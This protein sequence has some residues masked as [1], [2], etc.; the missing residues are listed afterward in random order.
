MDEKPD[1]LLLATADWDH[2]LWTN[3]QHV[4]CS[5]AA[6]GHRVLYVESLGLRTIQPTARDWARV[7]KRLRRALQSPR[8]VRPGIWVCAP[9]ILPGIAQ[10]P[11]HWLNRC[12]LNATLAWMQ[13]RLGFG[14]PWLWTYNPLT[15]KY[16]NLNHFGL[17]IYHAVD[18]VQEQPCMPREVIERQEQLLCAAV[19]QVF[20]TSPELRRKLAPMSRR[21]RYDPNVVDQA[22]FSAAMTWPDGDLPSDLTDIPEPRIGF[23]GAISTYKLDISLVASVARAQPSLNF[24]FIGPQGEGEMKTDLSLWMNCPNIYLLGARSYHD[25]P[26]Y[27]AGLQCGWLP[28]QRNAYTQ[29]MFPMK[30][31]EYLAA[32]LPVVA[33]AIDALLDFGSVAWLCEPDQNQFSRALQE[34]IDGEGPPLDLRLAVARQ[35]TYTTR[36]ERMMKVLQDEV[37]PGAIL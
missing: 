36:M 34:C 18:A 11:L 27:C 37:L 6:R 35:N 31:F 20:V 1:I 9:L 28:L 25:L 3:K 32:G 30:F 19:D 2:P 21:L 26:R 16:F 14:R 7:W 22:H 24:I 4:A 29:A 33:T 10:G 17:S 15:L 5:L 23:I 12:L 8:P 13:I